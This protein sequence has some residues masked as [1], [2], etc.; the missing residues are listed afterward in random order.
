MTKPRLVYFDFAGSRGEECRIALHLAGV[1]FDDVRVARADWPA[2]KSQSPFGSMPI[3]ELAGQPPLGESNA[4]LVYIGRQHGLHPKDDLQAAYHEALMS[5]CEELRHHVSPVLR[6]ADEPQKRNA[7]EELARNYLSVWGSN[8]ERQLGD[9][10]FVGGDKV[11]VV[12]IKLYLVVR[13]L[14]SGTVDHLPTTVFD[15]CPKLK[16]LCQRVGEHAGVKAWLERSA[17]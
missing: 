12:D 4:I 10:P 8:V 17:R 13:W 7:R 3:L 11:H 5:Y 15:H 6:I 1:D 2:R 14:I 9:H 16:R